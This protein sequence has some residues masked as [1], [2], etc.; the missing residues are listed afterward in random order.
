MISERWFVWPGILFKVPRSASK[1]QK[2]EERAASENVGEVD[3]DERD[4][5]L[6]VGA[7]RV[8]MFVGCAWGTAR[9]ARS[10]R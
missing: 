2:R 10:G 1:K 8:S 4:V 5:G 9:C 6:Y 7:R 3:D